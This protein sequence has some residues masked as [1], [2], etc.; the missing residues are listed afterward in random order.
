VTWTLWKEE[1]IWRAKREKERKKGRKKERKVGWKNERTKEN[2]ERGV[3]GFKS[4]GMAEM[5]EEGKC[6]VK[7]SAQAGAQ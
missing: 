5:P 7:M 3:D 2:G 6:D 1:R 4:G